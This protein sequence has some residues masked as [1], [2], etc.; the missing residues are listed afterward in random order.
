MGHQANVYMGLTQELWLVSLPYLTDDVAEREGLLAE[1]EAVW[2]QSREMGLWRL[3]KGMHD[4]I[5][6]VVTGAWEA[7][8]EAAVAVYASPESLFRPLILW[9]LTQ[10]ARAGTGGSGSGVYP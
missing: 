5:L 7:A 2:E 6:A 9:T 4:Q 10:L 3:G 1:A 8:W